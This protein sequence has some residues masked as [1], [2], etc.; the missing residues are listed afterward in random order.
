MK[1]YKQYVFILSLLMCSFSNQAL[2]E[3]VEG[4]AVANS[5][6]VGGTALMLNGAGVRTKFFFDIYVAAL[7]TESKTSDAK[8]AINNMGNKKV[9]MHFLYDE[10]SQE[11][12]VNGWIA[13]FENNQDKNSMAKLQSRLDTFNGLFLTMHK[14]DE[15][16]FDFIGNNTQVTINSETKPMI[17]GQDFQQA[18]LS[19]WLGKKPADKDLKRSMLGED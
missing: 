8:K 10:V 19:I 16:S 4:V 13:G 3:E 7:Y 17:Q 12:L 15:I 5:V 18:L 1:Q 9:W 6:T 11:K 14:G 2:A